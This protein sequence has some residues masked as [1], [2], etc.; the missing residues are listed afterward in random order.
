M[1]T[2]L[3]LIFKVI[4]A[5]I[6]NL[7]GVFPLFSYVP[8]LYPYPANNTAWLGFGSSL[9]NFLSDLAK[10]SRQECY[11]LRNILSL[12][13]TSSPGSRGFPDTYRLHIAENV[14]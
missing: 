10:N 7:L 11:K 4:M 3:L 8:G 5:F 2:T 13:F 14:S 1:D 12:I 9:S 6:Y